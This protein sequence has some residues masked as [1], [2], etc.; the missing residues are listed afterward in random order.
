MLFHKPPAM[1]AH[2]TT[3]TAIKLPSSRKHLIVSASLFLSI[4]DNILRYDIV[5][6]PKRKSVSLI[7]RLTL[8]RVEGGARTH[9]IQNHNLTL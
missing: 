6:S 1:A 9:D 7:K 2:K 4:S 3:N 8:L 5:F